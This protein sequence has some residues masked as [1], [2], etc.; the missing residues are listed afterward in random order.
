MGESISLEKNCEGFL[1]ENP[2]QF[3]VLLDEDFLSSSYSASVLV[4]FTGISS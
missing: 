3:I 2:L 1:K 4:A